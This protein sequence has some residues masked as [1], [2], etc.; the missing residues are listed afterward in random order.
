MIVNSYNPGVEETVERY[1]GNNSRTPSIAASLDG[2]SYRRVINKINVVGLRSTRRYRPA[3]S[4]SKGKA[5]YHLFTL[6]YVKDL[7]D[8]QFKQRL[9]E[10]PHQ[11][12]TVKQVSETYDIK[13]HD[14]RALFTVVELRPLGHYYKPD[15]PRS[16]PVNFY[17]ETAVENLMLK[18]DE[19]RT[20]HRGP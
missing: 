6:A 19:L 1:F 12:V 2:H 10:L 18:V 8:K 15:I 13:S 17:D 16:G 4:K 5:L 9:Y 20:S 11:C 3:G 14:I 7:L